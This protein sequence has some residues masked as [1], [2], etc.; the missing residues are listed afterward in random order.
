MH[1]VFHPQ[2]VLTRANRTVVS[3]DFFS[4]FF[5]FFYFLY[6]TTSSNRPPRFITLRLHVACFNLNCI[7]RIYNH[8]SYSIQVKTAYISSFGFGRSLILLRRK[9]SLASAETFSYRRSSINGNSPSAILDYFQ[10]W[11]VQI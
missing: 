9:N 10:N 11:T 8:L 7:S 5:F 2:Y 1:V 6:V 4:C 3:K